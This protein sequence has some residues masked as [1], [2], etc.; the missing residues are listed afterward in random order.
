[1]DATVSTLITQFSNGEVSGG[2]A[3][4]Q[5][6]YIDAL[7]MLGTIPV[8]VSLPQTVTP[9]SGLVAFPTSPLAINALLVFHA[10]VQCGELSV[11]EANWL[12]PLWRSATGAQAYN[13]VVESTSARTIVLVPVPSPAG[14]AQLIVTYYT[15]TL[16]VWLQMPVALLVLEM[17]Y[18]A[19]LSAQNLEL[20]NAYGSLARFLL[21]VL[22]K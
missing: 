13:F 3:Q 1:M 5:Q 17:A 14:S 7:D 11:R 10:N 22:T 18:R 8:L 12:A 2:S 9:S 16:P 19:E 21:H 6:F 4:S 20:A 15:D